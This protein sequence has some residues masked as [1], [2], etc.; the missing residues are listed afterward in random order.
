[1]SNQKS[2]QSMISSIEEHLLHQE[3]AEDLKEKARKEARKKAEQLS[4]AFDY[5]GKLPEEEP[6]ID[7]PFVAGLLKSATAVG[8]TA[9]ALAQ[10]TGHL[11]NTSQAVGGGFHG[12]NIVF[13]A[14]NVV[15][16]PAVFFAGVIAGQKPPIEL[17]KG[18]Q[19]GYSAALL[20]LTITSLAL[21]AL[22]PPLAIAAAGL[23]LVGSVVTLGHLIIQRNKIKKALAKTEK[24]IS[25]N[26]GLL[27]LNVKTAKDLLTQLENKNIS[28]E[29]LDQINKELTRLEHERPKLETT[30][31]ELKDNQVEQQTKLKKMG[32]T[33]F[34]DKG[35]GIGLASVALTGAILS[36]FFPPVGIGLLVGS[37]ALGLLYVVG[38]VTVPLVA[39]YIKSAFKSIKE[40]YFSKSD[41]D[42]NKDEH[43]NLF[44]ES[45]QPQVLD[46]H[47]KHSSMTEIME[48]LFGKEA[49][50]Q[51]EEFVTNQKNIHNLDLALARIVAKSDSDAAEHDAL[52]FVKH[53]AGVV[54]FTGCEKAN[55]S[56]LSDRLANFKNALPIIHRA[57]TKHNIE[58]VLSDKD[59]SKLIEKAKH[60]AGILKNQFEELEPSIPQ[61]R[62]PEMNSDPSV[63][64]DMGP[65]DN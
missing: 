12:A 40:K 50:K 2:D 44:E 54:D 42:E 26:E 45:N 46:P 4:Q 47:A 21:P 10:V 55:F 65:K 24:E 36:L 31:R 30:L 8:S 39:P 37:A 43:R 58:S 17:T 34:M 51:L 20:A 59:D 61:D 3:S 7:L 23:V 25:E 27:E 15:R 48:G 29:S 28:Q 14:V 52:V 16:I 6:L 9:T 22:A 64:L 19:W 38:R 60:L 49:E 53:L 57:I 18:A 62:G 41:E 13:S 32:L 5:E 33:A 63:N 35:V 11:S 1:M 56:L